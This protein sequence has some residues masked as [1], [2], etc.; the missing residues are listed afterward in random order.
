MTLE[1]EPVDLHS[2]LSGSLSIV[3]EKALNQQISVAIETTSELGLPLLDMRKTKQIVYNLLSNA[4]KFRRSSSRV[5]LSARR[6]LRH[7]VGTFAGAW[8]VHSF[9]LPDSPFT[10]F[11]EIAVSDSGLG[12]SKADMAKL[13]Q[14]FS[15]IDSSLARK[16]EGTGLGLAMVKQLAEL[17]GG[18]VAVSSAESKG[19]C[20]AVWLP[21]REKASAEN[22]L[23][24]P[25]LPSSHA[26]SVTTAKRIALVIEDNDKAANLVRLLLET[27]G[28][29]VPHAAS[30][31]E[32][33]Q[34]APQHS[35]SL[36]TLD[37]HLPGMD[38]W[39]FL[40]KIRDSGTQAHVPVV[41]I[42]GM[43]DS[44]MGLTHGAAAV[45]Q[46]P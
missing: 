3:K 31:E 12:I 26:A 6:V 9:P 14:A 27:E 1:L 13:S 10:E 41:I 22:S 34:I 17:Q 25:G 11:L 30:A 24:A 5:T 18:T 43:A 4:V 16:F 39:G 33:L 36:I 45:L 21:L 2:L 44:N 20:F 19:A 42:S 7:T 35:L 46:N 38:E 32:A 23:P 37:I 28:F 15:Q 40:A 8:P 29:S